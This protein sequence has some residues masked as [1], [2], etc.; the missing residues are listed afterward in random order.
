MTKYCLGCKLHKHAIKVYACVIIKRKASLKMIHTFKVVIT[1][2]KV[3][4]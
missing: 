4:L 3:Y 2:A 1:N